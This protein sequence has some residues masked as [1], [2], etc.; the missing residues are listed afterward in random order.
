MALLSFSLFVEAKSF[1]SSFI[2]I[3]Q[4]VK[5]ERLHCD[6]AKYTKAKR[7]L[8]QLVLCLRKYIF[9]T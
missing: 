2:L 9:Q 4:K 6:P 5:Y 7:C 3:P 1:Q 8:Y